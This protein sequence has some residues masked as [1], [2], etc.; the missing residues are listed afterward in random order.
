RPVAQNN[1]AP[2][3]IPPTVSAPPPP[4]TGL[5]PIGEAVVNPPTQP[6]Q[7]AMSAPVPSTPPRPVHQIRPEL[8]NNVKSMLQGEVTVQVHVSIDASGRVTKATPIPSTSPIAGYAGAAAANAA[9]LWR[10]EPS[11][12]A[13]Q[14]VPSEMVLEFRFAPAPKSQ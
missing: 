12:K 1:L 4:A 8:P 13:G 3:V 7:R 14:T 10:F 9:R 6:Q 5:R 2:P 11:R